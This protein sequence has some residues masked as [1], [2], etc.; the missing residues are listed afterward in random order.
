MEESAIEPLSRTVIHHPVGVA[1]R[2]VLG[3]CGMAALVVVGGRVRC[4]GMRGGPLLDVLVRA[5]S[6]DK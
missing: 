2:C 1:G 5:W 6:F 4:A 3:H